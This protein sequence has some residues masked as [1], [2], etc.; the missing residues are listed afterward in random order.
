M[1]FQDYLDYRKTAKNKKIS[2]HFTMFEIINSDTA[3]SKKIDNRPTTQVVTNATALIKNVLEKVRIHFNSPVIVNSI[4]R[5]P[6]LNKAVGGAVD[7]NGKPKSQHCFGQAADIT[8]KG[9]SVQEVFDYIKHNLIFDQIIFEGTWVHV[10][11]RITPTN[12]REALIYK[13]GKYIKV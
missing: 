6:D 4:Y 2:E 12:R 9:H 5:S 3:I 1:S 13:N 10:S 11:F 8:V 7:K